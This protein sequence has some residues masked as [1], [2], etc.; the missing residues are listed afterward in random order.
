M[1]PPHRV[2]GIIP[3]YA[4]STGS[5]SGFEGP[6]EDHPRVCGEHGKPLPGRLKAAGSSPRM[7]GAR[8]IR[9]MHTK[10]IRIIPAYAGSTEY[11]RFS[12][13][14]RWDHPRVCGEHRGKPE[15]DIHQPGS[16]PRMRGAHS[17][18]P[19]FVP[20]SGII[21]AYAGSTGPGQRDGCSLKDHPRVCGEHGE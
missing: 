11:H 8:T 2:V 19:D 20:A 3:A 1:I 15:G 4:G 14:L 9:R 16:S 10:T 13:R 18:T 7:R 12:S 6:D 17:D 5:M 21:P